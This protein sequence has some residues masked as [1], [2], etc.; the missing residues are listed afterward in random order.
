VEA[1]VKPGVAEIKQN[2]AYSIQGRE[3][4]DQGERIREKG[5][6]R[7]ENPRSSYCGRNRT[8]SQFP[9]QSSSEPDSQQ[10]SVVGRIGKSQPDE[11]VQIKGKW[12]QRLFFMTLAPNFFPLGLAGRDSNFGF[13]SLNS[14]RSI[15][16]LWLYRN[17]GKSQ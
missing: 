15:A 2:T 5:K 3:K 7:K 12:G 16:R 11:L 13:L 8:E 1:E 10:T 17:S 9:L 14:I 6:R 4:K